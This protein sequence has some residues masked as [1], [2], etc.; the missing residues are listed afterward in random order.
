MQLD[1]FIDGGAGTVKKHPSTIDEWKEAFFGR[2]DEV[3]DERL[4][5]LHLERPFEIEEMGLWVAGK[6][7]DIEWRG[8]SALLEKNLGT[9]LAPLPKRA[10]ELIGLDL[11]GIS[12]WLSERFSNPCIQVRLNAFLNDGCRKF[13]MDYLP[14]RLVV[15]YFGPGTEIIGGEGAVDRR[16]LRR[17]DLDP[18]EANHRVLTD[19]SKLIR[20]KAGDFVWLKGAD[21]PGLGGKGA[22]HR[23]PPIEGT[24]VRRFVL[25]L[26]VYE[27][28]P[29]KRF[30]LGFR[31]R[32]KAS[33]GPP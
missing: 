33:L 21:Y 18:E 7:E 30:D 14:L 22:V 19:P 2:F 9:L 3:L 23:S 24:G 27:I 31:F 6:H 32:C 1:Y 17:G 28:T 13:H 8:Q 25:R 10:Q 29:E 12:H 26:D 16:F 11:L 5:F 20:A 15:T 4:N